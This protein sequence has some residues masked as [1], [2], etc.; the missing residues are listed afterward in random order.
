MTRAEIAK[1]WRDEHPERWREIKMRS[2]RRRIEQYRRYQ[3]E[4][5]RAY[6]ARQRLEH[7]EEET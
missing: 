4:Y 2:Q 7:K 5:R 1:K 6:R 3:R